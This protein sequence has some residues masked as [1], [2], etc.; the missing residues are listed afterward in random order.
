MI[1]QTYLISEATKKS[2][3][4]KLFQWPHFLTFRGNAFRTQLYTKEKEPKEVD[5]TILLQLSMDFLTGLCFCFFFTA[6]AS[7]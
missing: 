4:S 6:S 1:R 5:R 2:S 7:Y 3:L